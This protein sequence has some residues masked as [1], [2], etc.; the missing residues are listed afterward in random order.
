MNRFIANIGANVAP[1]QM[2]HHNS[3]AFD[4]GVYPTPAC[5]GKLKK[6]RIR[7]RNSYIR[8]FNIA[9]E[10]VLKV[11]DSLLTDV[12]LESGCQHP[13]RNDENRNNA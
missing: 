5:H 1:S 9:V 6:G 10:A 2:T 4:A 11:F 13:C 7:Y 8:Q 3:L 12:R